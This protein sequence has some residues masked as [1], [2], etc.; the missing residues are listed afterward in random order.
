M[1]RTL[2]YIVGNC[3]DFLQFI[4]KSFFWR[5]RGRILNIYISH[6]FL[7][8]SKKKKNFEFSMHLKKLKKNLQFS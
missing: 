1:L 2:S 6:N 7:K 8:N 4:K 3:D 5:F